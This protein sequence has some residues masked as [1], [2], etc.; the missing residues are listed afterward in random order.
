[1]K[2]ICSCLK[3]GKDLENVGEKCVHPIDGLAFRSYG[4]YG[5]TTFD[6]LDGTWLDI[7]VCDVCIIDYF[8]LVAPQNLDYYI[9]DKG[10]ISTVLMGNRS[11]PRYKEYVYEPSADIIIDEDF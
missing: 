7:V 11:Q 10:E 3:C 5:S 8:K 2:Q 1:M 4:N 9:N 6:P